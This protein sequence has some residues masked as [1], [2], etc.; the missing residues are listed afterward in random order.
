ML[1]RSNRTQGSRSRPQEAE[2]SEQRLGLVSDK[3]ARVPAK[4]DGFT[5]EE[6][7]FIPSTGLRAGINYDIKY[8]MRQDHDGWCKR[9]RERQGMQD[10]LGELL[11]LPFETEWVEFKEAKNNFDFDDLG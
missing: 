3:I 4:H 5:D 9:M 10:T 7:D 6:L 8:R 11:A 2:R 1:C